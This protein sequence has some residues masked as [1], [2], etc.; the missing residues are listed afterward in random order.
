MQIN[1]KKSSCLITSGAIN[2][3][4]AEFV[5]KSVQKNN[6]LH[7]E[8]IFLLC[9]QATSGNVEWY[10]EWF[11][12]DV[13]ISEAKTQSDGSIKDDV[14]L[15]IINLAKNY[16]IAIDLSNG[17]KTTT[18]Y[19]FLAGCFLEID[20]MY[21]SSRDSNGNYVYNKVSAFKEISSLS[22]IANIDLLRYSTDLESLRTDSNEFSLMQLFIDQAHKAI[23]AFFKS[24]YS[25][26]VQF[27]TKIYERILAEI[28]KS[29]VYESLAQECELDMSKL[30]PNI[31]HARRLIEMSN[32]FSNYAEKQ[33]RSKND[34]H[35]KGEIALLEKLSNAINMMR[36]YRNTASHEIDSI[37]EIDARHAIQ[38]SIYTLKLLNQSEILKETFK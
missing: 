16:D 4:T 23:E 33:R 17:T 24:G 2:R 20:K 14:L 3:S 28:F 9:S 31:G 35:K 11:G 8:Q 5:A 10:R 32:L 12:E 7:I 13:I 22:K 38:T 34:I 6:E 30:S 18:S 37:S 21:I 1:N 26:S 25:E 15:R 27:A 19:L 36:I 29:R